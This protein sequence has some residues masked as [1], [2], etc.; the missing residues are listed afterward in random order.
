MIFQWFKWMTSFFKLAI[1][2]KLQG[3][4]DPEA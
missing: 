4:P 1:I 2:T 3:P